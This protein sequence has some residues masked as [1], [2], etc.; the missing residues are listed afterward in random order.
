[1]M[2]PKHY[3][4]G[5]NIQRGRIEF[6]NSKQKKTWF[7]IGFQIL[8]FIKISPEETETI[9]TYTLKVEKEYF[10]L[11]FNSNYH[12]SIIWESTL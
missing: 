7:N 2:C 4:F 5:V 6:N 3:A 9:P 12:G 8:P 1:M 11:K 10:T